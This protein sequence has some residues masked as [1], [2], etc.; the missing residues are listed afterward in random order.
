[1]KRKPKFKI[2]AIEAVTYD[3][4]GNTLPSRKTVALYRRRWWGWKELGKFE[5]RS[6]AIDAMRRIEMLPE[7]F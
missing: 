7:Y 2:D 6:E 1:M 4:G 3:W 5:D